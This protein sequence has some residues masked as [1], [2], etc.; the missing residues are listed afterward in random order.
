M[1][2]GSASWFQLQNWRLALGL[3]SL[4]SAAVIYI[5]ILQR[6]PLNVAQSFAAIQ[7]VGVILGSSFMLSE[8]INAIQWTGI[9][10]I[11]CGI[12]IV[13]WSHG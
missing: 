11:A 1:T 8:E 12:A 10:F 13:G 9:A 7:F 5:F 4:A 2:L 3:F 6:V